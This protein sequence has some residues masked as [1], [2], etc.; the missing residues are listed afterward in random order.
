MHPIAFKLGSLDI[1]W[2]GVMVAL[3]FVVGLWLATRRG[4]RDGIPPERIADLG[5]WLI[6]GTLV[7]ARALYVLTYWH[8]SFADKPFWEIF[9]VR[10]GGLVFYGGL[11]GAT[12][13]GG[14][15]VWRKKLPFWKTADTIAPSAALGFA[16]GRV[17]CLLNGCCF[18]Q[19]CHL[20]WAIRFPYD[21]AAWQQQLQQ[22]LIRTTDPALPVHPT[23]AYDALWAFALYLVLA[24]LYRRKKFD[25]QVFAVFLAG[26]AVM[27]SV[28]EAFRGDYTPVH[29]HGP[30]TPAQLVSLGV[31]AAAVVMLWRLPRPAANERAET[32]MAAE[33]DTVQPSPPP[34]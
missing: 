9:A 7:G 11:I 8:E 34:R 27:R 19:V 26:Y 3:G 32:R 12:L 28:V 22:G 25:G 1:Y 29:I 18:G 13:A 20:P 2:Y 15:F 17:G 16:I 31:F 30:F 33:S 6:I 10:N 23:E 24:W 21:S 5:T 14:L 4:L